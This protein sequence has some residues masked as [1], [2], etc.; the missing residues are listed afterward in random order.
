MLKCYFRKQFLG[1]IQNGCSFTF[2]LA[3]MKTVAPTTSSNQCVFNQQVLTVN[4]QTKRVIMFNEDIKILNIGNSRC[5]FLILW[6]KNL[7]W[8]WAKT[9]IY[10]S[11]I[12]AFSESIC[13]IVDLRTDWTNQFFQ[14]NHN[15]VWKSDQ[16]RLWL[17]S[18]RYLADVFSKTN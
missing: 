16:E 11:T 1:S 13:V 14:I 5:A 15:Y 9:V 10:L 3:W 12:V 2:A 7:Q 4:K 8:K 6:V 18:C 17:Y